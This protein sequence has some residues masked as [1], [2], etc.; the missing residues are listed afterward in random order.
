M[1]VGDVYVGKVVNIVDYG[2]YVALPSGP[3]VLLH[4]SEL[5]HSKVGSRGLSSL[6]V[7]C[8]DACLVSRIRT[9]DLS[10]LDLRSLNLEQA[11]QIVLW[12]TLPASYFW[13]H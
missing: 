3:Q 10:A 13:Y 11:S 5:S 12:L 1:Q 2:A 6:L 4:I 9:Q 8:L 7:S